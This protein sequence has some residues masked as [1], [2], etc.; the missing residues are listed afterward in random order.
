MAN[1]NPKN[2]QRD[3]QSSDKQPEQE[4]QPTQS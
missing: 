3:N 1:M 2:N 4:S